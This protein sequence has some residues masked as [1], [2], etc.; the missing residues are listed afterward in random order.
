MMLGTLSMLAHFIDYLSFVNVAEKMLNDCIFKTSSIDF[1]TSPVAI[2]KKKKQK[3]PQQ[4]TMHTGAR[5]YSFDFFFSRWNRKR[6]YCENGLKRQWCIELNWQFRMAKRCH[7]QNYIIH[8]SNNVLSTFFFWIK[9]ICNYINCTS[10]LSH[11]KYDNNV[12]STL[13]WV[14]A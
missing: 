5:I 8:N 10:Y 3:Q 2:I 12:F 14:W 13:K 6:F 11:L 7:V 4:H 1:G 9:Y